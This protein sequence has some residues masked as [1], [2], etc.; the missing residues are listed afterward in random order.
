MLTVRHVRPDTDEERSRVVQA[1]RNPNTWLEHIDEPY[2]RPTNIVTAGMR[3]HGILYDAYLAE[4][5]WPCVLCL[6]VKR[7][8]GSSFE[9]VKGDDMIALA[10]RTDKTDGEILGFVASPS[11]LVRF[12]QATGGKRELAVQQQT[13]GPIQWG[14]PGSNPS[15]TTEQSFDRVIVPAISS[16]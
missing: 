15:A 1:W 12:V 11:A 13:P 7:A 4:N 5:G 16:R 14:P 3:P 6:I 8:P 2:L 10:T 9:V